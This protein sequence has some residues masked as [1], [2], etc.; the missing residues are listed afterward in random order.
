MKPQWLRL[1]VL[2]QPQKTAVCHVLRYRSRLQATGRMQ[3]ILF[4]SSKQTA[5]NECLFFFPFFFLSL[6]FVVI[7]GL[8]V[9]G[10]GVSRM[11][12]LWSLGPE[13]LSV[14]HAVGGIKVVF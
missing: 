5:I 10:I 12:S 4:Q 8:S 14:L 9:Q 6:A 1:V 11:R 7:Q 13:P 3:R 2:F